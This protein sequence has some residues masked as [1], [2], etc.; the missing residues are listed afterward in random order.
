MTHRNT[1]QATSNFAPMNS[2]ALEKPETLAEI[3][4]RIKNIS[5]LKYFKNKKS[6]MRNMGID[7]GHR[8]TKSQNV[9]PKSK[10]R[11]RVKLLRL[12]KGII[13][14]LN[15]IYSFSQEEKSR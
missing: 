1:I 12:F 13:L 6:N 4:S 3:K 14:H 11:S 8:H 7:R 15:H 9:L 5:K 2:L 10:G